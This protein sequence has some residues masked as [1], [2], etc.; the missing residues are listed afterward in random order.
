VRLWRDPE[1][2]LGGPVHI[3]EE[4]VLSIPEGV[5]RDILFN[6]EMTHN[7]ATGGIVFRD[8]RDG[9]LIIGFNRTELYDDTVD[10]WSALR[11]AI[12]SAPISSAWLLG[13]IR[14]T[15]AGGR[16]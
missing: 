1:T 12:L 15:M 14:D 10:I 11:R 7:S 13:H 6:L 5:E 16:F 9:R 3:P 4:L 8:G 2:G